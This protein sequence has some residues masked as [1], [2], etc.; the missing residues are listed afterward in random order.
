MVLRSIGPRA[1]EPTFQHAQ[2]TDLVEVELLPSVRCTAL[3]LSADLI[4]KQA[5]DAASDAVVV[6]LD[7]SRSSDFVDKLDEAL[8][9]NR[10]HEIVIH[11]R[12][13]RRSLSWFGSP[14]SGLTARA[15]STSPGTYTSTSSD[16]QDKASPAG[17]TLMGP[18]IRSPAQKLPAS[19]PSIAGRLG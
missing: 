2:L 8:V 14:L 15:C 11:W 18:I 16:L 7:D 12:R 9:N 6:G 1:S 19:S 4:A 17:D 13:A 3:T 10:A 5:L